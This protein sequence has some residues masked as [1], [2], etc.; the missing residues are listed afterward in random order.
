MCR[1]TRGHLRVTVGHPT[2]L[3]QTDMYFVTF[4]SCNPTIGSHWLTHTMKI[5]VSLLL[6]D[7]VCTHSHALLLL[8][9]LSKLVTTAH[10]QCAMTRGACLK[11]KFC[12][13]ER[14]V[15]RSRV[16]AG[17]NLLFIYYW[18]TPS[19]FLLLLA[20]LQRLVTTAHKQIRMEVGAG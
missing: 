15:K 18:L 13:F 9:Q 11:H 12:Q 20:K 19:L 2:P 6:A 14:G 4:E 7:T 16:P 3:A 17:L 5:I 8:V 10:E 1:V